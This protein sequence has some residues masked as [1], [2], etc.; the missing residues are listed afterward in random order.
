MLVPTGRLSIIIE[1]RRYDHAEIE[2]PGRYLEQ[3]ID[4]LVDKIGE[5]MDAAIKADAE[6]AQRHRENEARARVERE[7]LAVE[8]KE[9]ERLEQ[10]AAAEAARKKALFEEAKRWKDACLLREYL[11]AVDMRAH[12]AGSAN[13]DFQRWRHWASAVLQEMESGCVSLLRATS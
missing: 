2:D 8:R 7:R 12:V 11:D 6:S 4:R 9:R 13:E 1:Y 5:S 3:S 10:L